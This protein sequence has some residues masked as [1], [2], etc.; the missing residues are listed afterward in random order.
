LQSG[1]RL[2]RLYP[3]V[4]MKERGV[5]IQANFGRSMF[6]YDLDQHRMMKNRIETE[7]RGRWRTF[8]RG[9]SDFEDD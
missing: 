6:M 4:G 9:T 8:Q 1:A 7:Q 2:G 3:V 5:K